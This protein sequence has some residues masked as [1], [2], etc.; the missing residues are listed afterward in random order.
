MID[1]N[2][3]IQKISIYYSLCTFVKADLFGEILISK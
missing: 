1:L 2:Q 3:L